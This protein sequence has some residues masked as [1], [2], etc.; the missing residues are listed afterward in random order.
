MGLLVGVLAL[1]EG[2]VVMAE[3]GFVSLRYLRL[4]LL[5]C[6]TGGSG[7]ALLFRILADGS[8]TCSST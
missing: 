7:R 5:A 2:S 4:Y 1:L 3:L 8:F 6:Q